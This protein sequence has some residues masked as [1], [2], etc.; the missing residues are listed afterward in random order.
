MEHLIL[1]GADMYGMMITSLVNPGAEGLPR[2]TGPS[3]YYLV[4]KRLG[5]LHR[6]I[7]GLFVITAAVDATQD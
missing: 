2:S 3:R 5:A 4:V 7:R 1:P 6:V